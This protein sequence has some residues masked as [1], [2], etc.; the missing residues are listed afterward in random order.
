MVAGVCLIFHLATPKEEKKTL[1]Q[2][3]KNNLAKFARTQLIG[4]ENFLNLYQNELSR[5]HNN[6]MFMSFI[7]RVRKK[8]DGTEMKDTK[9]V[10]RLIANEF[11]YGKM[12]D[13]Y[14][15]VNQIVHKVK[16]YGKQASAHI[17]IYYAMFV[18]DELGQ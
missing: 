13:K 10:N 15:D 5:L 17:S 1:P 6:A 3:P 18:L 16:R 11:Y 7:T 9:T 2:T 8:L 12:N 4:G 14:P